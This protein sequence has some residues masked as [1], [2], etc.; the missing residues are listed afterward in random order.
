MILIVFKNVFVS[1]DNLLNKLLADYT[2]P[3]LFLD[4]IDNKVIYS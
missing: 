4:K 3:I 2:H 1:P